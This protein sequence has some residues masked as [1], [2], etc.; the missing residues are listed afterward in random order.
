[1]KKTYKITKLWTCPKCGRQFERQ[2]QV[3]SCRAFPLEQH[4]EGKPEGKKLYEIFKRAVTKQL[5]TF[6]IESLEC[7]IHFVSK[8]TFAAVKILKDKIRVDF[9]LSR[10]IRDKRISNVVQMSAHRFLYVIDILNADD[11]DE[12]LM[13]WIKEAHE[14]KSGKKEMV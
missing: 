13:E 2:G 12:V 5:G 1:V 8:F 6:K 7:C 9:S 3:H 4:F 14:K 11:I 10:K